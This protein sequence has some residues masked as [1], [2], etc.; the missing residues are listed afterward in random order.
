MKHRRMNSSGAMNSSGVEGTD[1]ANEQLAQLNE[2]EKESVVSALSSL[3]P[4]MILNKDVLDKLEKI[5]KELVYRRFYFPGGTPKLY[6]KGDQADTKDIHYVQD[7]ADGGFDP[8]FIKDYIAEA[9]QYGFHRHVIVYDTSSGKYEAKSFDQL[10]NLLQ[11][12]YINDKSVD[13]IRNSRGITTFEKQQKQESMA[14]LFASLIYFNKYELFMNEFKRDF[15]PEQMEKVMKYYEDFIQDELYRLTDAI[16]Q[17]PEDFIKND[18]GWMGPESLAFDASIFVE[19]YARYKAE[20]DKLK[21]Q[22]WQWLSQITSLNLCANRVSGIYQASDQAEINLTQMSNCYQSVKTA[23]ENE[24][25]ASTAPTGTDASGQV[26]GTASAPTGTDASGQVPGNAEISSGSTTTTAVTPTG[27]NT[28]TVPDAPSDKPSDSSLGPSTPSSSSKTPVQ[29][30]EKADPQPS[31]SI[32]PESKEVKPKTNDKSDEKSNENQKEKFPAKF[33]I[34]IVIISILL[35]G[36]VL[37]VCLH[38]S[39]DKRPETISSNNGSPSV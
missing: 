35:L 25:N 27:V 22:I 2:G 7:N 19:D 16:G 29:P 32:K 17:T 39:S 8:R 36:L 20:Y 3:E 11:T 4:L 18:Y 1:E 12:Y 38:S 21:D 9:K 15:K 30:K 26:P 34:I 6:M 23:M 14:A 33:I 13:Y 5:D 37:F 10:R 31:P 24:T 28:E